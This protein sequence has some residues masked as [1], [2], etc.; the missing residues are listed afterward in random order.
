VDNSNDGNF[1]AYE[2]DESIIIV[3]GKKF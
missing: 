1:E 2:G 3:E